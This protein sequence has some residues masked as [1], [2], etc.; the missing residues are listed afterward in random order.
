[1]LL[2]YNLRLVLSKFFYMIKFRITNNVIVNTIICDVNTIKCNI[3]LLPS[4]CNIPTHTKVG[5]VELS[6]SQIV[7]NI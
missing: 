5:I 7:N 2:L 4:R 3:V 1:M 6:I